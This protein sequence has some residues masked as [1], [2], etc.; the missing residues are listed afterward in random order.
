MV[1]VM[2][3]FDDYDAFISPTTIKLVYTSRY[4]SNKKPV[5]QEI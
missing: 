5:R 1:T 4:P 2:L 3:Q